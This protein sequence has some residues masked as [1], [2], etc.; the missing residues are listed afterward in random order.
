MI[1]KFA[2]TKP[3]ITNENIK[4]TNI[5]YIK[6]HIIKINN[7]DYLMFDEEGDIFINIFNEK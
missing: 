2:Y 6:P 7:I 3:N 4:G 5:A 1:C